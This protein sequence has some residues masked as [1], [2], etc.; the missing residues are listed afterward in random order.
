MPKNRKFPPFAAIRAFEA[1]ARHLSFKEAAAEI[2]VTPSAISHQIRTLE[3][4]L[5]AALFLREANH[6]ELTST[7]RKYLGELTGLL[8]QLDASTRAVTRANPDE[9][10]TV[11]CTPGFAARWLAPRLAGCPGNDRIEILVSTGAPST[12]F[13]RNSA[14][15]VIAWCAA[16]VPGV[17][18]E[19]LMESVRYP[20]CSPKLR[21]RAGLSRP[22]D[23][24]G[25]PLLHDEVLD[26][27]DKWFQLAGVPIP[28]LP[29][30]P[31]LPHCELTLSAAEQ[32]QGV[33][34]AYDA[35]ARGAL[36]DGR[37]VRLFDIAT[38]PTTI[39]SVAYPET[40][41]RCPRIRVFRNWIF[42][43]VIAEG[44]QDRQS[45]MLAAS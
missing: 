28:E 33:A 30:G 39:Y 18:V 41:A 21:A 42:D 9:P 23:L 45:R 3:K 26:A 16:R 37:L 19:P 20:V 29:R 43:E 24:L 7:G 27:W 44:T 5:G 10:L 1:A 36:R 31:R 4:F 32:G 8:D 2:H 35:M 17:I 6:T 12:D 38:P 34:L 15:V 14:E 22:T 11:L 25:V 40:R 13:A